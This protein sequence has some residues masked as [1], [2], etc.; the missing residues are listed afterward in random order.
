[1]FLRNRFFKWASF[2]LVGNIALSELL[3][4]LP[5]LIAFTFMSSRDGTLTWDLFG[6]VIVICALG[7]AVFAL[8]MW[9][10]V[11]RPL[12]KRRYRQRPVV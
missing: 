1:M 5:L 11:A 9:F 2:S 4:S 8:F 10:M 3:F 12:I 7:G 6:Y